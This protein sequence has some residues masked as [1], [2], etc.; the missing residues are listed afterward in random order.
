V[1]K[2]ND[3]LN[4]LRD[5]HAGSS[6]SHEAA[7]RGNKKEGVV[8][9][10]QFESGRKKLRTTGEEEEESVTRA[11]EGASKRRIEELATQVEDLTY[12][13]SVLTEDLEYKNKQLAVAQVC[14]CVCLMV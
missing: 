8:Q 11:E 3:E 7:A 14:A 13:L 9:Q 2:L 1:Q 4:Q 10:L 5:C 6:H 12:Q